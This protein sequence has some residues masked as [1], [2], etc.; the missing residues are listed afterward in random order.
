MFSTRHSFQRK[1]LALLSGA[2]LGTFA[3]AF[4]LPAAAAPPHTVSYSGSPV[5]T[6]VPGKSFTVKFRVKNTSSDAYSGVKATFHVPE[7]L[8]H[9]SVSPSGASIYDDIV[10][11]NIPSASG[12][13]FYPS[14]TF[15]VDKS[16]AIGK[17]L[18]LWIEVT[19]SGMETTSTNFSITTVKSLSTPAKSTLT[20][21]DVKSLFQEIYG[22]AP[23]NSELTYWL[24]RRTDKPS[25]GALLGAMAYHKANNISH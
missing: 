24:G 7:G 9:T 8:K 12:Q 5:K 20:S 19:G 18:N 23:A 11:W 4:A 6:A 16:V 15:T 13:S 3:A 17:K 22:R 21:A 25:R 10:S 2:A 14:F 1:R